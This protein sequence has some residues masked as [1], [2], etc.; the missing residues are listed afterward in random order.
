[1]TL[2]TQLMILYTQLMI[3]YTKL[4]IGMPEAYL[5]KTQNMNA[6]AALHLALMR[7]A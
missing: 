7:E 1:M 2:Y 5:H 3:V 4:M 6:Q